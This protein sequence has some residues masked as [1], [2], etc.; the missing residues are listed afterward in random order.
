MKL[1]TLDCIELSEWTYRI[2]IN[3]TRLS[4]DTFIYHTLVKHKVTKNKGVRFLMYREDIFGFLKFS[5][6]S[7]DLTDRIWKAPNS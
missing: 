4:V 7:I 6:I 1:I 5:F 3:I 2:K